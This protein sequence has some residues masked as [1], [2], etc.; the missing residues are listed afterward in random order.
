MPMLAIHFFF[1][2][3]TFNKQLLATGEHASCQGLTD[4]EIPVYEVS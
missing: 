1:I 2:P 4:E 3:L